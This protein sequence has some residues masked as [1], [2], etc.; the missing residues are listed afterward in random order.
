MVKLIISHHVF[1]TKEER[2]ELHSGTEI[3][4]IGVSVP[5]WAH[6]ESTTEP[7]TEVFVNY[8]MLND[9]NSDSFVKIR[10]DGYVINLPQLSESD[11]KKINTIKSV[12]NSEWFKLNAEQKDYFYDILGRKSSLNLLDLEDNGAK[13]LYFACSTSKKEADKTIDIEN[14]VIIKDIE[15]LNCCDVS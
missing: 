14:Y 7:A 4:T 8:L 5:V 12:P 15:D 9:K 3:E 13:F 2:Y 1:L 6:K 11:E 10:K